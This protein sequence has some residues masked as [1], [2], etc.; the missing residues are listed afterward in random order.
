MK[1]PY[2]RRI[3]EGGVLILIGGIILLLIPSEIQTFSRMETV[4]SPSFLP[5]VV[6]VLLMIMGAGLILQGF[7][8]VQKDQSKN[9]QPTSII[10]VVLAIIFLVAYTFLFPL[11]G[12]VVTSALFFFLYAYLF[13][14]HNLFKIVS[15][16]VIASVI[17]W[18]FFEKLFNIPLPHGILF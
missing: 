12:F 10:R 18:A 11:I 15:G 3:I 8:N 7:F 9:F 13:G 16:G 5:I 2:L 6:A 1:M 4:M 17:V 14:M